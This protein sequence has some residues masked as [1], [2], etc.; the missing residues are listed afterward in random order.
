MC[1]LVQQ[2]DV[3]KSPEQSQVLKY[4]FSIIND[5]SERERDIDREREIER[6]IERERERERE[7]EREEYSEFQEGLRNPFK[8]PKLRQC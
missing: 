7:G 1:I 4:E 3:G 2:F 8:Q 6:E 5:V